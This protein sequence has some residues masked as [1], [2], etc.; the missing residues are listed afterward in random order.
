MTH[1]LR[2]RYMPANPR[3]LLWE[4]RL[5][6][7]LGLLPLWLMVQA[8]IDFSWW[9]VP[10]CLLLAVGLWGSLSLVWHGADYVYCDAVHGRFVRG[11]CHWRYGWE[12]RQVYAVSDFV[13]VAA[14]WVESDSGRQVAGRVWLVGRPGHD[15]VYFAD[16]TP[17]ANKSVPQ[18]VEALQRQIARHSGLP[19][20]PLTLRTAGGQQPANPDALFVKPPKKVTRWE[21]GFGLLFSAFLLLCAGMMAVLT[22]TLWRTWAARAEGL[23]AWEMGLLL[24]LN[25]VLVLPVSYIAVSGSLNKIRQYRRAAD[26][27]R[28]PPMQGVPPRQSPKGKNAVMAVNPMADW[29]THSAFAALIALIV[30]VASWPTA[31]QWQTWFAGSLGQ[32]FLEVGKRL[33]WLLGGAFYP[34]VWLRRLWRQQRKICYAAVSDYIVV[35]RW[36]GL[37]WAAEQIIAVGNVLGIY[38]QYSPDGWE[39]WLAGRAGAHDLC[40]GRYC[41][42]T[43]N[44][45]AEIENITRK[46]SEASGLPV[47]ARQPV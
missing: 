35:Y 8:L 29:L 25:L 42:L 33:L 41:L 24:G 11:H 14:E 5:L 43:G 19:V 30:L 15:D 27:A 39:I 46:L 7:C 45:E 37:C 21:V 10:L 18:M 20:L 23:Q 17:V 22:Q 28:H 1:P 6:I 12:P 32:L 16:I 2:P 38:C 34:L 36:Q 13:G 44:P 4:Q 9:S 47:L 40:L 31:E 3:R 26:F